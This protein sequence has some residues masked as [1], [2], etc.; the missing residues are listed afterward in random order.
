MVN[1][2]TEQYQT[3]KMPVTN[4]YA[5]GGFSVAVNIGSEEKIANLIL[6]TGSSTLVVR[7]ENYSPHLDQLLMPTSYAQGVSYGMGGWCGEVVKTDIELISH[8]DNITLNE[9]HLSIAS[10]TEPGCFAEADGILGLAFHQLN[11]AHNLEDYL[12]EKGV[13]PLAT[14]PWEATEIDKQPI[15][16]L[17]SFLRKYPEEDIKPYFTQLEE[18]GT[19]ANKFSFVV[20]R[21]S[22]HHAAPDLAI[23]QLN[24]DPLNQGLFILGGGEEQTELHH[25]DFERVRVIDDVY[26]NVRLLE[27]KIGDFP[28][29]LVPKLIG[30]ELEQHHSNAFIDTGAS[31]IVL[32]HSAYQYLIKCL[33]QTNP[34]FKELLAP[35]AHFDGSEKGIQTSQLKLEEWPIIEFIFEAAV[36][37]H[38][39]KVSWLC[40][41][42]D[43]WQV[44]T[45]SY[46]QAS[47]KII[48][49]LPGWPEQSILGL[50]LLAN[51]YVIFARFENQY[52]DIK[53]ARAKN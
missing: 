14:F 45:P 15:K 25:D 44:N 33:E 32:E 42:S 8:G 52:G 1:A 22:I 11:Q 43:Y 38:K 39:E 4:V 34:Q 47:F 26:Y 18:K 2:K 24:Q 31:M 16:K 9:S 35:F 17:E 53:F 10:I 21:S 30:K 37:C 23:T 29:F 20:K 36:D 40:Q 13:K 6:D 7:P 50:P 49:Q 5:R 3:L 28:A 51:Y 12:K 27:L 46:G 41:P 19:T 48:S